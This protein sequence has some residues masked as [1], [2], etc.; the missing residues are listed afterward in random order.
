MQAKVWRA[1][2][3]PVEVG[4]RGFEA[5]TPDCTTP[6]SWNERREEEPLATPLK[7][8]NDPQDGCGSREGSHGE[9]A[10]DLPS[11]QANL[12]Q[13]GSLILKDRKHLMIQEH[14]Y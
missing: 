12:S 13:L 3:L 9:D 7:Q 4:C 6:E 8:Q 10:A 2:C 11:T 14:H 1:K 5:Q